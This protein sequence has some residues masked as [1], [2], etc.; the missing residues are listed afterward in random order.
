MSINQLKEAGKESFPA[1]IPASF[2]YYLSII[3][4][5]SVNIYSVS[6]LH[7]NIR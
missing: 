6:R 4:K 5:I 1:S 7:Q 3:L 2:S